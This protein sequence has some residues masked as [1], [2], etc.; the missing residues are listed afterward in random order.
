MNQLFSLSRFGR[1]ALT[2]FTDNR[3]QLL[4]NLALLIGGLAA[5]ALLCYNSLPLGVEN[6]RATSFFMAGWVAWYAFIWQQTDELNH[7]ERAMTYLL[8]PASQFEKFGLLWLDSGLGFI[9]I[10]ALVFTGIDALGISY[11]NNRQ[12]TT[13]QLAHI[14]QMGGLIK[15]RPYYE[16][17]NF[18]PPAS[19][20]VLSALLHPF[21]LAFLLLIRRYALP[22]V[23]VLALGLMLGGL[24]A[25][26]FVVQRMLGV[27]NAVSVAPFER[28]VVQSPNSLTYRTLDIVQP[29]G[30]QISV[31]VAVIAVALLYLA[32]YYRLKEREI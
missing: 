4:A 26:T 31:L 1:L 9:L 16:S 29:V 28:L 32:A 8:R 21:A 22:L 15:L 19:V 24:L 12:W 3:G 11:V 6:T 17:V 10:Y 18:W 25:N 27:S 20:L 14:R 2:Y 5:V 23:A 13:N 30:Y 7:K